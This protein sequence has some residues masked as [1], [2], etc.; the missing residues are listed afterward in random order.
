MGDFR[1]FK[2]ATR[3][4]AIPMEPVVDPA[5]WDAETLGP[6]ENFSYFF[7]DDDRAEIMSAVAAFRRTGERREG[8]TRENFPLANLASALADFRQELLEGRGI[9]MLRRFPIDMLDKEGIA[10]AYLGIGSYLGQTMVQNRLGHVL[11][12]VKDLG[13]D[14]GTSGRSYNTNAEIRFHSDACDYVGLLCLQSAKQGGES[15]VASSVTLYNTM[16]RDRPDLVEAL[17]S[18]Y[19]RSHNGEISEGQLPYWKQPMFSFAEGYFSAIGAGSTIEKAL[20]L[21]GVPPLTAAQREAVDFYRTVVAD[22]AVDIDFTPGDI[23]LLNN[24]VTL[25]SRRSFEDFADK[26]RRRHLLRLWLRDPQGRPVTQAQREGR[27]GQGIK[28]AGL[29]MVAPLEPQEAA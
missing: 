10:I 17:T 19:Y 11:G 21:P 23:Q 24:Y 4:P 18:D 5:G 2:N 26:E 27:T 22:L 28:I 25:H 6:L 20:R 3:E 13:E 14:Y 9:V 7:T 16:L 12:H 29:R 15:R 8:V 1:T